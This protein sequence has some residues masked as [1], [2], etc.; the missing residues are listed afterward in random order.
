MSP[1]WIDALDGSTIFGLMRIIRSRL[2][3]P[4]VEML[5]VRRWTCP[6]DACS[7]F[8]QAN[9]GVISE[10]MDSIDRLSHEV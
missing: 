8:E 4:I 7:F 9:P 5:W 3:D 6:F 10:Q 2:S 1:F